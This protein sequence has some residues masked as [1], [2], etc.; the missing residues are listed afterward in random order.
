MKANTL[1]SAVRILASSLALAIL[2]VLP[3]PALSQSPTSAAPAP[4]RMNI[5]FGENTTLQDAVNH[6]IGMFRQKNEHVN[7]LLK[8]DGGAVSVP[9]MSLQQVT[10]EQGMRAVALA[11][12]PP[13]EVDG[14][15]PNVLVVRVLN[16]DE[17]KALHS[18][19]RAFNVTEFL[20]REGVGNA[21]AQL[22]VL[23]TA[24]AAGVKARRQVTQVD[25][26]I[27]EAHL[28]GGLL[29]AQGDATTLEVVTEVV[30][31][32]CPS[33]VVAHPTKP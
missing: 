1:I 22:E 27:L 16:R 29:F 28:E 9:V 15:G 8:G 32:L 26:P 3:V 25:D 11:C 19:L 2:S 20:R 17:Q 6:L 10:F 18:K 12:E 24:V 21:A 30:Q 4:Q 31:A 13:V 5:D 33:S 23:E 14:A 7:A